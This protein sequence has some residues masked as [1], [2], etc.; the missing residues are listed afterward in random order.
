MKKTVSVLLAACMAFLCA[1]TVFG[2]AVSLNAGLEALQDQFYFG[3]G[4]SVNGAVIDYFAYSPDESTGIKYPLVVWVHGFVS[5]GYPGRQITKNDISYWASKEFQAR[6]PQGGAHILAPRSPEA[7]ASWNGALQ[8]P[9]KAAIDSFVQDHYDSVDAT[10]IYIGGLSVGARMTL[11]MAASY[12]EMF[13]AVFPCSPYYVGLVDKDTA[14][15]CADLPIWMLSSKRDYLMSFE[16]SIR[17]TWERLMEYSNRKKDC[18]WTVMKTAIK[19]DGSATGTTHDTWYAATYDMFMLDNG[20]FTDSVT[21]D[22]TGKTVTL[23]YPKGMIHWLSRFSSAYSVP[24]PAKAD[25]VFTRI[26]KSIMAFF[27]RV[28]RALGLKGILG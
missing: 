5:G 6:F 20:E 25:N 16:R 13:A 24:A 4:P 7:V 21:Y 2:E 26:Y 11:D 19:P 27:A 15:A 23:T 1:F 3:A 18:R 28:A 10:R 22:G 17:P 14:A 9:L 8:A 12:P